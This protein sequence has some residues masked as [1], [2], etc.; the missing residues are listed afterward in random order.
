MGM[1]MNG[2]IGSSV[3]LSSLLAVAT[4]VALATISCATA[5]APAAGARDRCAAMSCPP[6]TQCVLTGRGGAVC[7]AEPLQKRP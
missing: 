3:G 2:Q 1:E 4:A 6:G 7:E 5:G